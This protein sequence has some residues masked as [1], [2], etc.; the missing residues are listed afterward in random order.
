MAHVYR[1]M[2]SLGRFS[3]HARTAPSRWLR[4]GARCDLYDNE[5][6]VY[7]RNPRTGFAY[8]PLDNV[9]V[10]Y[11]LVAFNRGQ[12]DARQFIDL[13]AN[14]GGY[15]DEGNWCS[16]RMNADPEGLRKAYR[17]GLV[18]TG[19]GGLSEVPIIDVRDYGDDLADPHVSVKSFETRA[20]LIAANGN[21]SNQVILRYPRLVF[22]GAC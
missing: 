19:G 3:T 4:S 16:A 12:I 14:M 18:L 8:R 17:R 21:A 6:N 7:G 9:G 1:R 2:E 5:I 11:G 10:Q 15:D 22:D 13:N 20:R